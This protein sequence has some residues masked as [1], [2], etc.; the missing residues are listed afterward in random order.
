MSFSNRLMR[1]LAIA[2][3]LMI[4]AF[5]NTACRKS[6]AD[7][8]PVLTI[9][10]DGKIVE[11]DQVDELAPFDPATQ[12]LIY[13][14][15]LDQ[16]AEYV[17]R[18]PDSM[19]FDFRSRSEYEAG[20]LPGATHADWLYDKDVFQMLIG[21]LPKGDKYLVYGSTAM[22]TGT[23]EAIVRLR[24]IGFQNL[25]TFY[26]SYEAWQAA[27]LPFE[28]GPDPDPLPLPDPPS[29]EYVEGVSE[30]ELKDHWE[31]WNRTRDYVAARDGKPVEVTAPDATPAAAADADADAANATPQP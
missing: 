17:R 1:L 15:T 29:E 19:I 10:R 16:A 13:H 18:F 6:D 12:Q 22:I 3:P 21:Q 14:L 5:A 30:P 27:S 31:M 28:Q 4:A 11:A 26:E 23:T 2:A 9:G 24:S 7:S 8:E 20:H 25:H